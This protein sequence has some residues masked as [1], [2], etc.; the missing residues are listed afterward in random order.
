MAKRK[1]AP[2]KV[3]FSAAEKPRLLVELPVTSPTGKVRVKRRSHFHEYGEP[4]ATRSKRF[5]VSDYI[6]WQIGYDILAKDGKRK[7]IGLSGNEF[8][9]SKG[10]TK[11]PYELSELLYWSRQIGFVSDADI[12]AVAESIAKLRPNDL[13]DVR[14][15]MLPSRTNPVATSINGLSFYRTEARYPIVFHRFGDYDIYAE[16]TNREKQKAVGLQPMLYVCIPLTNLE[17]DNPPPFGRC[18]N[19][20]EICR[21]VFGPDEGR[22]VL[23]L[24]RIFGMLS[25]SHRFDSLVILN[26]LFPGLSSTIIL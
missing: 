12:I 4:V 1:T 17:F 23:E 13:F 26:A 24:F 16:I 8:K 5:S 18:S 14:S 2:A 9:N 15:D 3:V 6:E 22:L 21:W 20:N 10:K 19:K 11:F 7:S 25:S